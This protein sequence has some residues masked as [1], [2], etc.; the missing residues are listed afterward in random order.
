MARIIA[1]ATL[2]ATANLAPI[3][4]CHQPGDT[5]TMLETPEMA[6][7]E[8]GKRLLAVLHTLGVTGIEIIPLP[9]QAPIEVART[10]TPHLERW[11]D[12]PLTVILNGGPKLVAI[13]LTGL[14][15]NRSVRWIYGDAQPHYLAF[16]RSLTEAPREGHYRNPRL[17]LE[18]LLNC[19]T[20]QLKGGDQRMYQLWPSTKPPVA[21]QL[22]AEPALALMW[23]HIRHSVREYDD[24]DRPGEGPRRNATDNIFLE[25]LAC[26]PHLSPQL[27]AAVSSWRRQL[28]VTISGVARLSSALSVTSGQAID[29]ADA[30]IFDLL[31]RQ[32]SAIFSDTQLK[33]PPEP[34]VL[35]GLQLAFAER[36]RAAG[37]EPPAINLAGQWHESRPLGQLLRSS[38]DL[39]LL[40]RQQ[41]PG[42]A[43]QF[44]GP[45]FETSV[46]AD[47]LAWLNQRP[48]HHPKIREVWGNVRLFEHGG[49]T[50]GEWDA[51]LLLGNGRTLCIESKLWT[52]D[53]RDLDGR[54]TALRSASSSI[55]DLWL[56]LPMYQGMEQSAFARALLKLA[57]GLRKR[58]RLKV[59]FHTL[60]GQPTLTPSDGQKS[61][62]IKP[63]AEQLDDLFANL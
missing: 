58:D 4:E 7:R 10:L 50:N 57:D 31:I 62:T 41:K 18:T 42:D 36:L 21:Q 20:V 44:N 52:S 40:L 5:L 9:N 17:T 48:Q 55:S 23:Q 15:A 14:L 54:I 6:N 11:G 37:I 47:L 2:Q 25:L 49:K 26:L 59:L 28:A 1:V 16:E 35:F 56:C 32:L 53:E 38:R 33:N 60:H 13:G 39:L 30:Q 12:E 45:A 24:R 19:S 51:L 46:N 43:M 3:L 22:P 34:A 27:A 8:S 29:A 63:F 61:W